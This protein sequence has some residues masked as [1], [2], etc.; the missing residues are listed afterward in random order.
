[1]SIKAINLVREQFPDIVLVLAGTK[2]IIDWELSQQKDIAYFVDLVKMF[3]ERGIVLGGAYVTERIMPGVTYQDHG[4]RGDP[5]ADNI[6]RGGANN[7]ISP[8]RTTSPNTQ[9]Q[10]ASGF[11]VQVE[12]VSREQLDEWMKQY[13][14][15]F[16]REYDADSGLRFDSWV[17]GTPQE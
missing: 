9:G 15:A 3:N 4:A 8:E 10:V 6:D 11:L 12:K 7:L 14:E 17:E 13:P 5:I 16:S 1:M 2:N